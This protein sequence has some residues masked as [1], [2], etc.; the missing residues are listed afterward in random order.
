MIFTSEDLFKGELINDGDKPHTLSLGMH[1][2]VLGFGD[3]KT[4]SVPYSH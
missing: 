3:L 2:L 1:T 4:Y